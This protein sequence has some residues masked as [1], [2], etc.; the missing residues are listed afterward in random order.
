MYVPFS[1][2]KKVLTKYYDFFV[3]MDA[4]IKFYIYNMTLPD[5]E[6]M[7]KDKYCDKEVND[8]EKHTFIF[9]TII[10]DHLRKY[11]KT[12][13]TDPEN[14]DLFYVPVYFGAYN[15]H[16]KR[17]K[18]DSVVV[19]ALNEIGPWMQRNGG[20]D[21][22]F[23]QMLFSH[24]KIPITQD[25][26]RTFPSMITIGDILFDYSTQSSREAWRI[27]MMPYLTNNEAY[28]VPEKEEKRIIPL[29]FIGQTSISHYDPRA[30]LVRSDLVE[31]MENMRYA[32]SIITKRKDKNKSADLFG[33]Y[34]FMKHSEFCPIP[35]GDGPTSKRL[36]DAFNAR[37]IPII[38]SD[39]ARFPFE[40]VFANYA[41]AV[42]QVPMHETDTVP[43]VIG[44]MTEEDRKN[45]RER[46][47]ELTPLLSY[48]V[49]GD[50]KRGDLIWAWKWSHFFK[51]AT[52]A[53]SKRRY[54][55][56]NR[57]Y[58]PKYLPKASKPEQTFSFDN[59]DD[60]L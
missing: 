10:Q 15:S 39:E 42:I 22:I 35:M 54:F 28:D 14:A 32:V 43:G 1:K 4:P 49:N 44:M 11:C 7:C 25:V 52:I 30:R 33:I 59:D 45:I 29:F 21:H 26:Q 27:T 60:D 2:P 23:T 3:E 46:I 17:A 53:T 47:R 13:V 5:Q 31:E 34:N 51:A 20:V 56:S 55:V 48:D 6:T 19:P 9:E 41:G 40:G 36:Y 37:C 24:G 50:S 12:T 38:L 16:A 58:V 57:Y 18:I 8:S